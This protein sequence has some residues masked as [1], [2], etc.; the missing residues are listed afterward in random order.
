MNWNG[1]PVLIFGSGGISKE[2]YNLIK[3]INMHNS[4]QVYDVLGFVEDEESKIG[5]EVIGGLKVITCDDALTDYSGSF[6]VI[7]IVIPIGNP[8][9]KSIIYNRI[10]NIENAV[11]PNIVHPSI[12]FD[13]NDVKL[14]IGNII[15]SGVNLTCDI[16]IGNF[17]LVNLNCTIGHDTVVEDFNVINP[18]VA[19]SGNVTIKNCCLIGTGAKILQQLRIGDNAAVGSGAVVIKDVEENSTVVGVPAKRIK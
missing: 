7:G 6:S 17:N 3:Q 18:L 15:T 4:Q 13:A 14:G 12:K 11:Y 16:R 1:L 9:V 8:K 19:V 5:K 2:T 10:K